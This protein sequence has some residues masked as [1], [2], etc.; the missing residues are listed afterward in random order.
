V[1]V[2]QC[3]SGANVW[4]RKNIHTE[5]RE[6]EGGETQTVWVADEVHGTLSWVPTT[7]QVEEDFDEM[8]EAFEL[9]GKT[10]RELVMQALEA[11]ELAQAQADFTAIMTDTE[12]G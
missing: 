11:A 3:G 2:E 8:G 5:E 1:L 4:L 9:E 12:V 6:L 10:D 7:Q